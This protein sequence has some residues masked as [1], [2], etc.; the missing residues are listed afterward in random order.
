M[1]KEMSK[2]YLQDEKEFRVLE[3]GSGCG[4]LGIGLAATHSNVEVVLT[5]AHVS[6]ADKKTGEEWTSLQWLQQNIDL[7]CDIFGSQDQ[8]SVSK[9]FW[10]D[11]E[12]LELIREKSRK[13]FDIIVGSEILYNNHDAFEGL[14]D[15]LLDIRGDPVILIGYKE[16]RL[17]ESKFFAMAEDYFTFTKKKIG[18]RAD[19]LYLAELVRK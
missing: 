8:V 18:N 1:I 2:S 3:L 9:L 5:D 13:E 16:R 7:N 15:T 17:G 10:G 11:A 6:F 19:N 4:L 14:I 12:D